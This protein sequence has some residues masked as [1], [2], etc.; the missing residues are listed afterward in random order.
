[1]ENSKQEKENKME[2]RDYHK[3]REMTTPLNNIT[4]GKTRKREEKNKA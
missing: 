4:Q 1:M 2:L 3:K